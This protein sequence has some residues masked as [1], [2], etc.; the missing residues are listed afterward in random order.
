MTSDAVHLAGRFVASRH[1]TAIAAI[2]AGSRARAVASSA[3]D[4]DVVLLFES[5][6]NGAWREMAIFE[7]E[8]VEVFAHDLGPLAYF[9]RAGTRLSRAGSRWPSP[10]CS[11][12]AM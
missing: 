3:S 8:H 6:P 4:Y 1:P 11:Q 9:C 2:L 7:G 5:L 12:R 10:P